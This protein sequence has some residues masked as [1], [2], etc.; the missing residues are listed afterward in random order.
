MKEGM[1]ERLGEMTK[2]RRIEKGSGERIELEREKKR[3][4]G[5]E[6]TIRRRGGG[7]SPLASACC[8]AS[9]RH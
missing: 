8:S 2:W 6:M 3:Q 7:T 4:G 9:S 5:V 1:V